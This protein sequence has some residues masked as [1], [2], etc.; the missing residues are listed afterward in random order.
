MVVANVTTAVAVD[1][2]ADAAI[3]I[4]AT[5]A[6]QSEAFAPTER[7]MCSTTVKRLLPIK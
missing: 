2:V 4:L 1:V 3:T 6:R 7:T 5:V